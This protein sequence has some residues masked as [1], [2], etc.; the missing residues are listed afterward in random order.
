MSKTRVKTK[1]PERVRV[2]GGG[3]PDPNFYLYAGDFRHCGPG[4]RFRLGEPE[5][6]QFGGGA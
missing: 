6:N 1:L 3:A 5:K 4:L 2:S